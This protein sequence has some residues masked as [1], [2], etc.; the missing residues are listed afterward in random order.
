MVIYDEIAEVM[1]NARRKRPPQNL[2][3]MTGALFATREEKMK[4][5]L[6]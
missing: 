3:C 5:L 2:A 1:E 4:H 6:Y